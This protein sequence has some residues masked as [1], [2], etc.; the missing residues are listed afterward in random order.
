LRFSDSATY[1]I[2]IEGTLSSDWSDRLAGLAVTTTRPE[3][4][5][6][7]T[8]LEGRIHDQTELNGVI[9]TLYGLHLPILMVEKLEDE[10]P[11]EPSAQPTDQ[12]AR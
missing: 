6:P 2:V 10:N 8:I 5:P 7:R 9:A 3:S 12:E 11:V 1:R 4:R